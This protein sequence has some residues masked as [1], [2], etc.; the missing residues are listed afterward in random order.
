MRKMLKMIQEN[1]LFFLD[2]MFLIVTLVATVFVPDLV[3]GLYAGY[4]LMILDVYL[5]VENKT[6]RIFQIATLLLCALCVAI[7]QTQSSDAMMYIM[8]PLAM[9]TWLCEF[10]KYLKIMEMKKK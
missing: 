7:G 2:M 9:V 10:I 6:C 8:H 3:Y 1:I 5:L 4:V